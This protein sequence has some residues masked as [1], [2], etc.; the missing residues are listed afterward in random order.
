MSFDGKNAM[1]DRLDAALAQQRHVAS[2]RLC[3]GLAYG[4]AGC[5]EGARLAREVDAT[6]AV[7]LL[8]ATAPDEAAPPKG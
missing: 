2:C 1:A 8:L 7:A 6:E 5:V 4:T 3:L